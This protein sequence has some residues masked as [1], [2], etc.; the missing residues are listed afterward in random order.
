M[1]SER[2]GEMVMRDARGESFICP[3]LKCLSE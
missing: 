3:V 2:R 1:V